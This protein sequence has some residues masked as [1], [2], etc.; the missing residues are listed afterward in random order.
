MQIKTPAELQDIADDLRSTADSLATLLDKLVPESNLMKNV[1][2]R[3]PLMILD[4]ADKLAPKSQPWDGLPVWP[5]EY[6][7]EDEIWNTLLHRLNY[8]HQQEKDSGKTPP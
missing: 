5:E 8:W 3:W 6:A 4:V 2:L 1:F 7:S